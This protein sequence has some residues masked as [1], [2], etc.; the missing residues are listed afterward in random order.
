MNNRYAI[1]DKAINEIAGKISHSIGDCQ[2]CQIK[3]FCKEATACG[4]CETTW[5]EWLYKKIVL[6]REK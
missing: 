4:T 1:D 3:N 6:G 5:S 2:F